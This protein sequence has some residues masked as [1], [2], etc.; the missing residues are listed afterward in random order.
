MLQVNVDEKVYEVRF[1]QENNASVNDLIGF[2]S[3]EQINAMIAY[4][5]SDRDATVCEIT[6]AESNDLLDIFDTWIG[7]AIRRPDEPSVKALGRKTALT[8]A[9]SS[10]SENI[11]KAIWE[12]Y[13]KTT[14]QDT[15]KRQNMEQVLNAMFVNE[16]V[17]RKSKKAALQLLDDT[18]KTWLKKIAGANLDSFSTNPSAANDAAIDFCLTY[19]RD[20]G[21]EVSIEV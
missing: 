8:R 21:F 11:R 19:L 17:S 9:L 14:L 4:R 3:K 10:L 18:D 20:Q 6:V 13:W 7:I 15:Q 5:G 2:Y 16:S 1:Y 12:E